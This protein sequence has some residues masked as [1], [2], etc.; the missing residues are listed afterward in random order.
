MTLKLIELPLKL[1]IGDLP[2]E[3]THLQRVLL[4]L[5][6]VVSNKQ[7]D[8][9]VIS[10]GLVKKFSKTRFEWVEDLARAMARYLKIKHGLKGRLVISKFPK[11]KNSPKIFQVE[12]P[13]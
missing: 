12:L 5:E 9:W 1:Y 11:P 10:Q 3:K 2:W 6:I 4:T 13:L 7:P 8:Y